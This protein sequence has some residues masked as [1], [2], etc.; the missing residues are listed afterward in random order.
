MTRKE[1]A[2]DIAIVVAAIV[3]GWAITRLALYPALGIPENF[4]AILR[5][6][7]GFIAATLLLYRRGEAWSSLGFRKPANGWIA[8][9]GAVALYAA[10]WALSRWAVPALAQL[11]Q[12]QQ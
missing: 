2:L 4:P 10:N 12:P 5:P 11:V 9:A 8:I 3:A 1:A 6:I 7:L